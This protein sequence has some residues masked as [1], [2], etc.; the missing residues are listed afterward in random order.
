[1]QYEALAVKPDP[2]CA[3]VA[4]WHYVLGDQKQCDRWLAKAQ[5]QKDIEGMILKIE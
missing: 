3:V 2:P 5:E 1:L 4:M